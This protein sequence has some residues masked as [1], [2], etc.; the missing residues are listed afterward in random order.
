M[1]RVIFMSSAGILISFSF[2][3]LIISFLE[4]EPYSWL[5]SSAS[6]L[7]SIFC[8]R[9]YGIIKISENII[10]ASR[11]NLFKGCKVISLTNSCTSFDTL[12]TLFVNGILSL[13]IIGIIVI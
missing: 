7:N 5:F 4:I 1:G 3:K 11:S 10:A 13:S 12:P 2:K 6:F 9:P 8:S